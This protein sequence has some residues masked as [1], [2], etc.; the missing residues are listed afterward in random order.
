MTDARGHAKDALRRLQPWV[1]GSLLAALAL[2][3]PWLEHSMPRHMGIELPLLF[4]AGWAA[5]HVAGPRLVRSI[6]S[7][8]MA[9]IP[10]LLYSMLALSFWMVPAALDYA[11]LH[12]AFGVLKVASLVLA[13]LLTGVSWKAAGLIIQSFFALNWFWMTFGVGLL[14]RE[15][16]QQL[17][18]VYLVDEQADAGLAMMGW[19]V[20]GLALWISVVVKGTR[21]KD[22]KEPHLYVTEFEQRQA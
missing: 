17:C 19:A 15:M 10:G 14:Y 7:W 21:D 12:G 11:V 6:A 9:G 22:S 20:L 2:F 13:G 3:Q 18:S 5:A 16:P 4:I 8:N 1:P